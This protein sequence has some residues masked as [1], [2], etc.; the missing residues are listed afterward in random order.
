MLV[1]GDVAA[2]ET[3]RVRM[4]PLFRFAVGPHAGV[5]R[6]ETK[7]WRDISPPIFA[8]LESFELE[9]DGEVVYRDGHRIPRA[10]VRRRKR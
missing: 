2:V 3:S 6:I 1:D 9:I 8:R 7:L 10:K 5:I 4:A